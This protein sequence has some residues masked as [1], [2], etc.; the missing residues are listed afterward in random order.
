MGALVCCL[1]GFPVESHLL[2]I[3]K[4]ESWKPKLR[5]VLPDGSW[6]LRHSVARTS[7]RMNGVK[8]AVAYTKSEGECCSSDCSH[9][10][11]E[12]RMGESVNRKRK[13]WT[14]SF[15]VKSWEVINLATHFKADSASSLVFL[16]SATFSSDSTWL[17]FLKLCSFNWYTKSYIGEYSFN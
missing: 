5:T 11:G 14:A 6:A 13:T 17:S 7:Q 3:S 12:L 16:C 9:H 2:F 1:F 4:Q 10:L 8:A 15:G